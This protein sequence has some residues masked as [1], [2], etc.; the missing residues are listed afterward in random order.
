MALS[1]KEQLLYF[2][3]SC[4]FLK[5]ILNYRMNGASHSGYYI[6][7]SQ[8]DSQKLSIA[9]CNMDVA[10]FDDSMEKVVGSIPLRKPSRFIVEQNINV[11]WNS[12]SDVTFN[13][14]IENNGWTLDISTG[15]FT[16][17][18]DGI[19]KFVLSGTALQTDA[20]ISLVI[21]SGGLRT[22][23]KIYETSSG[24]FTITETPLTKN[25][26]NTYPYE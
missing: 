25:F 2:I 24:T 23:E 14:V 6:L 8:T 7:E 5:N 21:R 9:H 1:T 16:V 13:D 19:Y 18:Y 12:G 3:L 4:A 11:D 17:P 26:Y 10:Y 15:H 22:T 20:V